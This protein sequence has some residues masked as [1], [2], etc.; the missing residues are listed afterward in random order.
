VRALAGD[1]LL[2][3]VLC[4]RLIVDDHGQDVIEYALLTALVCLASILSMNAIQAALQTAYVSWITAGQSL[5][6][7][8]A[9]GAGSP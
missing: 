5:S 1:E 7:M 2:V 6:I 9:P 3:G 8:P 4:G